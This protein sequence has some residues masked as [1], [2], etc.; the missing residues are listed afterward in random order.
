VDAVGRRVEVVGSWEGADAALVTG[1]EVDGVAAVL[2]VRPLLVDDPTTGQTA[3][4]PV[5][6]GWRPA[7]DPTPSVQDLAPGDVD[8]VGWLRPSEGANVEAELPS[9]EIPG[10][11]WTAAMS[12]AEFAQLWSQPLYSAVLV[13]EDASSTFEPLPPPP[14]ETSLD[15]RSLA[16]AAEWWIFGLF[17][18]VITGRWIRDN[19]YQTMLDE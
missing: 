7:G 1:R 2:L 17:V 16:Y 5:V 11:F 14:P 12:A 15:V 9:E 19:R 8:I 10:T 6:V 3:T 13:S 18:L 4:L